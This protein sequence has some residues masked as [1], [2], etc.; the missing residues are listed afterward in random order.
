MDT[1]KATKLSVTART[2]E[3]EG[4]KKNNVWVIHEGCKK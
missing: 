1:G 2:N 3:R 4:K